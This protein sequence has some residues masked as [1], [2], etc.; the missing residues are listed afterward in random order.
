M[1]FASCI[2]DDREVPNL[3]HEEEI[4]VRVKATS[5]SRKQ[6]NLDLIINNLI[7]GINTI[8]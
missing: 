8:T 5:V 3:S 1:A 6:Q 7:C 2:V 4:S